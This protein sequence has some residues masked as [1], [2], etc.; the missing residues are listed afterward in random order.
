MTR[1]LT[2]EAICA[3]IDA[4]QPGEHEGAP[5]VAHR[6]VAGMGLASDAERED[7]RARVAA[8]FIERTFMVGG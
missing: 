3:L 5:S 8:V 2:G 6:V 4:A 1:P 7:M